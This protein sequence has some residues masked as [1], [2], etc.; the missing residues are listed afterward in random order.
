MLFRGL[1]PTMKDMSVIRRY[2]DMIRA[3]RLQAVAQELE[4]LNSAQVAQADRLPLAAICRRAGLI[5]TGLRLLKPLVFPDR[6]VF[7]ADASAAEIA[8]Y[9]AL[10]LRAGAAEQAR[11]MLARVDTNAAPEA[12]LYRAFCLFRTWDYAAAVPELEAYLKSGVSDY[13]ALVGKV[14]LAASLTAMSRLPEAEALLAELAAATRSGKHFRLGA[15]VYELRA[16]VQIQRGRFALARRDLERAARA[17]GANSPRDIFFVN[18]WTAVI[19]ALKDGNESALLE[20]RAHALA[21]RNWESLREADRYLLQVRFDEDRFH[22]LLFGTP[23]TGYRRWLCDEF[24]REAASG[25][26]H[27]RAAGPFS[28]DADS[29]PRVAQILVRDFYRPAGVGSLFGELF[30]GEYFDV[31]SSPHRVHQAVHR[32]RR[33]LRGAGFSIE[34]ADGT[35]HF[36]IEGTLRVP[37]ERPPCE[38][39]ALANLRQARGYGITR[40]QACAH[41]GISESRFKRLMN[42]AIE[43]GRFTRQGQGAAVRYLLK[44]RRD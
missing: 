29:L 37:L 16:Q 24:G 27:L 20:F 39:D 15:N 26:Y 9:A 33:E 18:K 1:A 31:D 44:S 36:R 40:R 43:D 32:A 3:G 12:R 41:L 14:N 5:A 2:E 42:A 30:P 28:I 21:T 8:E 25:E 38:I 7:R 6:K 13:Q 4:G 34:Q 17:L 19:D 22:H 35:Y 23:F 10:I 11:R